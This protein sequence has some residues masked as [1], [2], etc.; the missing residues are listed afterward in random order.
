MRFATRLLSSVSTLI[1][2]AAVASATPAPAS[3][4]GSPAQ[5]ATITVTGSGFGLKQCPENSASSLPYAY[6][7]FEAGSLNDVSALSCNNGITATVQNMTIVS[8]ARGAS[9]K[10]L[11]ADTGWVALGVVTARIQMPSASRG[12]SFKVLKAQKVK[13]SLSSYTHINNGSNTGT[14]GNTQFENWKFDR[15]YPASGNYPNS[16]NAQNADG[17]ACTGG[18]AHPSPTVEAGSGG[19][20]VNT[21]SAYRLPYSTFMYEVRALQYSS[22]NNTADGLYKIYQDGQL[23]INRSNW[24]NDPSASFP[25]TGFA[26]WY[27]QSDPSNLSNCGGSTVEHDYWID[28]LIYDYGTY[29]WARTELCNAST[30]AASTKCEYQPETSA[31]SDGTIVFKEKNGELTSNTTKYIY[32]YHADGSVNSNGL[33]L[34]AGVGNPPPVLLTATP[35][36][37]SYQG[38]TLVSLT[39]TGFVTGFTVQFG[40]MTA[41]AG[42][43]VSSTAGSATTPGGPGDATVDIKLINP[44]AQSSILSSTFTYSSIPG[45][46]IVKDNDRIRLDGDRYPTK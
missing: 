44:D 28:D 7:D 34:Q 13:S 17:G 42:T 37:G 21:S 39:G 35:S 10:M 29:A 25:S 26:N 38:G 11:K 20:S 19:D 23:N 5:D 30:L 6:F 18:G 8:E 41:V 36:T 14:P 15:G 4:S 33:I 46:P 31:R 40:T 32:V 1:L 12:R 43:F 9:T 24:K 3:V 2:F 27:T 45:I 22:A 16:Y